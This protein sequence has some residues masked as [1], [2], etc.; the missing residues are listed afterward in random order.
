MRTAGLIGG[1][2][3][4]STL[5]YYR[6]I[7]A[8]VARAQGG[9]AS[10]KLVLASM[11]FEEVLRAGRDDG[12]H[13]RIYI[14]AARM[15]QRAGVDFIVICSNTGHRRAD[16]IERATG[17]QVLHIADVTAMAVNA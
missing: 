16:E 8:A 15:L 4:H 10:A 17:L 1:V 11:N 7:N 3:W 14:D 2:S 5:E 9:A 13:A 12:E 6:V